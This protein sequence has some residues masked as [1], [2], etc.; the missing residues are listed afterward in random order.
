MGCAALGDVD[1]PGPTRGVGV[2]QAL[3]VVGEHRRPRLMPWPFDWE[4]LL[5]SVDTKEHR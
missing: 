2:E 4:P 1:Q 5:E 3:D